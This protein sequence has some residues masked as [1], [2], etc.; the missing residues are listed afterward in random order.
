MQ[1]LLNV[2]TLTTSVDL[3][4]VRHGLGQSNS[5]NLLQIIFSKM[6]HL[7]E[8]CQQPEELTVNYIANSSKIIACKCAMLD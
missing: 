6:F 2:T 5:M 1:D 3:V 4:H 8:I 7:P